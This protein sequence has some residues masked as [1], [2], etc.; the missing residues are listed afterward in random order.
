MKTG[1]KSGGNEIR[2]SGEAV[3]GYKLGKDK[4]AEKMKSHQWKRK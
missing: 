3:E 1:T 2:R 4:L